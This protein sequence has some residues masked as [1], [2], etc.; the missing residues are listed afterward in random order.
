MEPSLLLTFLTLPAY[1]LHQYEEH[2][3]DRFRRFVN[4]VIGHGAEVL[5][6]LEVFVVNIGLVWLLLSL[7]ILTAFRLGAGWGVIAGWLLV[8]NGLIH[9]AQALALRRYNPGLWTGIAVF[10][11]LGL[12]TL[13]VTGRTAS[14]GQ[15]AIAIALVILIH[16]GIVALVLSRR[17]RA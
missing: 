15:E 10:L 5:T 8:V 1:M 9:L 12:A 13:I 16:A 4:E 17:P 2:D 7:V 14:L 11:P 6:R 3:A